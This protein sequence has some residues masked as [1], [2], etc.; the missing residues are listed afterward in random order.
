MTAWGKLTIIS[1]SVKEIVSPETD[2][3]AVAFAMRIGAVL[4]RRTPSPAFAACH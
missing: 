2:F 3:S 4:I 1:Q